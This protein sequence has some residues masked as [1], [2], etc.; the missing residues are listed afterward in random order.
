VVRPAQAIEH[1]IPPCGAR[2]R[3]VSYIPAGVCSS[4][5]GQLLEEVLMAAGCA[6]RRATH[7]HAALGRHSSPTAM[8][9]RRS[10]R[11][12]NA[13]A[14]DLGT[15]CVQ[16]RCN[17]ARISPLSTITRL[18][19]SRNP[20]RPWMNFRMST[21]AQIGRCCYCRSEAFTGVLQQS[22]LR[23]TVPAHF[24]LSRSLSILHPHVGN[25]LQPAGWS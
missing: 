17:A 5:I 15:A 10:I 9:V 23:P 1:A 7:A 18:C 25:R 8:A 19:G 3:D 20:Q 2:G 22:S 16:C 4:T 13:G 12:A 11:P 24:V 21:P 6:F 14:V